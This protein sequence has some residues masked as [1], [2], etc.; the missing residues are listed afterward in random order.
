[1]KALH[2]LLLA[3][4][5]LMPAVGLTESPVAA[6]D[7]PRIRVK[8]DAIRAEHHLITSVYNQYADL[9]KQLQETLDHQDK[10]LLQQKRLLDPG[11]TSQESNRQAL[12]NYQQ[13]TQTII[14]Q[15]TAANQETYDEHIQW[16]AEMR[17]QADYLNQQQQQ[18]RT[19]YQKMRAN[20]DQQARK[21]Q[22][23]IN[24][25]NQKVSEYNQA[26]NAVRV[27]LATWLS[28]VEPTL[29]PNRE[30]VKVLRQRALEQH[31]KLY[32]IHD[33]LALH[34]R[35]TQS[36]K[37]Q[38]EQ[39]LIR[40]KQELDDFINQRQAEITRL[41][42]ALS[43]SRQLIYAQ[44]MEERNLA[45]QQVAQARQSIEAAFSPAHAEFA[46]ALDGWLNDNKRDALFRAD[47]KTPRFDTTYD[48]LRRV[49][50]AITAWEQMEAGLQQSIE[51]IRSGE[52][53]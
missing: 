30:Q 22:E 49:Y 34:I 11:L 16:L 42:N 25:Y 51:R 2:F 26:T 18:Q 32:Q 9:A 48:Q 36:L 52:K 13:E 3:S 28:S 41:R 35:T 39:A 15:T 53:P 40:A 43:A 8:V 12:I 47:G 45:A 31:K 17:E 20:H 5:V 50:E 27:E 4:I 1:M 10:I 44:M 24:Q 38:K 37:Q 33:E 7:D 29:G 6:R 46:N 19:L 21:T 14:D 23:L